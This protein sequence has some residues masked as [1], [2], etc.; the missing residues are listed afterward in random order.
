MI[1]DHF[2]DYQLAEWPA[3]QDTGKH[4]FT[5]GDF[6]QVLV[7]FPHHVEDKAITI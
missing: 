6:M 1:T 3:L 2:Y 5:K 7:D 4:A